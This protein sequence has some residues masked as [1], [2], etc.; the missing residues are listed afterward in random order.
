MDFD[1]P[2]ITGALLRVTVAEVRR[3]A[4]AWQHQQRQQQRHKEQQQQARQQHMEQPRIEQQQKDKQ[5]LHNR[6]EA[7]SQKKHTVR[8]ALSPGVPTKGGLEPLEA[9]KPSASHARFGEELEVWGP[10][11]CRGICIEGLVISCTRV[12]L[13][14]P[15][16]DYTAAT[17]AARDASAAHMDT[18]E[19]DDGTGVIS[20][21]WVWYPSGE[22][23]SSLRGRGLGATAERTVAFEPPP[24]VEP[25]TFCRAEGRVMLRSSSSCSMDGSSTCCCACNVRASLRLFGPLKED[26]DPNAEALAFA[27]LATQKRALKWWQE[28]QQAHQQQK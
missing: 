27:A 20:C 19:L 15:A 16:Q 11:R 14:G 2:T 26:C 4:A 22:P 18:I 8:N 1:F 13:R 10:W 23:R 9:P 17:A 7:N 5:E 24:P 12:M 6:L 25:G 21:F 28:Q 3:C